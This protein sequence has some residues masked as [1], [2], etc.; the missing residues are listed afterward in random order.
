MKYPNTDQPKYR[1]TEIVP[2][3]KF[4][5]RTGPADSGF[6]E[7]NQ[8]SIQDWLECDVDEPCYKLLAEDEIIVT[9]NEDQDSCDDEGE[10]IKQDYA[11]IGP[12]I[13]EEAFH[14]LEMVLKWLKQQG[15]FDA[16]Q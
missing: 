1:F 4:K 16:L 5:F 12:Y 15:E 9:G 6:E 7:C 13:S 10:P 11:E 2:V 3:G 14:R 8:E